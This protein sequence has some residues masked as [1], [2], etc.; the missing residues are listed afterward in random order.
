MYLRAAEVGPGWAGLWNQ[1]S[2]S[3]SLSFSSFPSACKFLLIPT[4]PRRVFWELFKGSVPQLVPHRVIEVKKSREQSCKQPL[5][6]ILTFIFQRRLLPG[7]FGRNPGDWDVGMWGSRALL[8]LCCSFPLPKAH[9]SGIHSW[10]WK[11]HLEFLWHARFQLNSVLLTEN[12]LPN[13]PKGSSQISQKNFPKSRV[14]ELLRMEGDLFP[15]K[16]GCCCLQ[17][18][19]PFT[20]LDLARAILSAL[21]YSSL[22]PCCS[23]TQFQ[24]LIC[25]D[26]LSFWGYC[27]FPPSSKL[28]PSW[29]CSSAFLGF[30]FFFKSASP[31]SL[32][33]FPMGISP[34]KALG[35]GKAGLD[36]AGAPDFGSTSQSAWPW[37]AGEASR[38]V[39]KK[40]PGN[41]SETMGLSFWRDSEGVLKA[42]PGGVGGGGQAGLG[43]PC[44]PVA[45]TGIC[46]RN[47]AV[48]G[49]PRS[50]EMKCP[51]DPPSFLTETSWN[52]GCLKLLHSG[53]IPKSAFSHGKSLSIGSGMSS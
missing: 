17:K 5:P 10:S 30:F 22:F 9:S 18:I 35:M 15:R 47:F 42:N 8:R 34:G 49:N 16:A 23:S 28:T 27:Y 25:H 39:R 46:P 32:T 44:I 20:R 12:N 36:P 31:A 19:L 14:L 41:S 38:S 43:S 52:L 48:C 7:H 1:K 11:I 24:A 29:R 4:R 21:N 40:H 6:R 37:N 26:F 51:E 33:P 53:Q 45:L 3:S 2:W 13:L 50:L